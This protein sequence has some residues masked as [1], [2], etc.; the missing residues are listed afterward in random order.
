MYVCMYVYIYIYIYIYSNSNNLTA[1]MCLNE[2]Y[3]FVNLNPSVEL[4][5]HIA[6]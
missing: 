4:C 5:L 3:F 2:Q 6:C 1:Q